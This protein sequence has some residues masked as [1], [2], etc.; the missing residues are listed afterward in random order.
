MTVFISPQGQVMYLYDEHCDLSAVGRATL[1]RASHV[2]PDGVGRWWADLAPVNGPLLGSF[3]KR[4]EAL[5]AEVR[6]LE[7]RL[8]VG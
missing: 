3:A 5:A 1:R 7:E 2:E 4:S 8:P 6:W